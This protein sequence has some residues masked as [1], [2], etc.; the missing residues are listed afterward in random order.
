MVSATKS[1]ESKKNEPI[2]AT[3]LRIAG[4]LLRENPA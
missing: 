3:M 2:A 1:P 4:A